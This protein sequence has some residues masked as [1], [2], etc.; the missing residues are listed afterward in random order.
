MNL[1]L[2]RVFIITTNFEQGYKLLMV[3]TLPLSLHHHPAALSSWY[4]PTNNEN[5]KDINTAKCSVLLEISLNICRPNISLL[6]PSRHTTTHCWKSRLKPLLF[7]WHFLACYRT[8]N[9]EQIRN[10]C[11]TSFFIIMPCLLMF[12]C[13]LADVYKYLKIS[14]LLL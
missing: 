13:K 7:R 4:A 5:T 1:Q 6:L 3:Q 10:D 8:K 14:S 12:P 11:G 2:Q 9:S